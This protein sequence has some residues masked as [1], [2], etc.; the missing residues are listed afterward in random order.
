MKLRFLI[1]LLLAATGAAAAAAQSRVIPVEAYA[2]IV[3][4]RIIFTGEV[5]AALRPFEDRLRNAYSPEVFRE[6][7]REAYDEALEELVARA[8]IAEE[9][10]SRKQAVPDRVLD[11]YLDEVVRERFDSDH[12][13][14]LKALTSQQLTLAEWRDQLRDQ[15]VVNLLRRQEVTDRIVI[16]PTDIEK[17]YQE[18]LDQYRVPEQVKLRMISLHR[19]QTP[20]EHETKRK[21]AQD[22]RERLVFGENFAALAREFGEGSRASRGGDWGWMNP[23]DLRAELSSVA[24]TLEPGKVSD[25]IETEDEYYLITVEA[26]RAASVT[27]LEEVSAQ[28]REELWQESY[29]SLHKAWIDGL[30]QKHFVKT[31]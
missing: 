26:R 11:D 20:A 29:S 5:M 23:A 25:V 2:A 31:F 6:K 18:R 22:L 7:L 28:L 3:N 17:R 13:E 19:G 1:L 15:F 14:L 16:S 24:K 8:L 21:Q 30:K 27:P 12:V 10:A 4:G 9:F